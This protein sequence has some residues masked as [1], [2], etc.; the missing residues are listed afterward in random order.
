MIGELRGRKQAVENQ[1]C[2]IGKVSIVDKQA[3][4]CP[5]FGHYRGCT[6]EKYE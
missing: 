6:K 3:I 1:Q 5:Y 2:L 4:V